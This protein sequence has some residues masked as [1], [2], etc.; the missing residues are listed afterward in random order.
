MN[1]EEIM[2]LFPADENGVSRVPT[3]LV[4]ELVVL[5]IIGIYAI[6]IK[7]NATD[8]LM[9]PY[10]EAMEEVA[11]ALN[12]VTPGVQAKLQDALI[13]ALEAGDAVRAAFPA[14]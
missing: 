13:R 2:K 8:E 14:E 7:N 5:H 9:L 11:N 3:D 12:A 10:V 4:R 6:A 1:P